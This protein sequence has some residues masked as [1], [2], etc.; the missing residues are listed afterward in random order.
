M[1]DTERCIEIPWAISCYEGEQKVLDIGYA[2]AEDRYL[3][4]IKALRIP[5]LYGLDLA[6][7]EVHGIRSVV[8]DVRR[9]PFR[10][11]VFDLILCISTIE[12]VG[13]D[14]TIYF[15]GRLSQD[16]EG[17]IPAIKEMARI[18]RREGRIVVT[19]PYGRLH[20]YGWFQQYDRQRLDKLISAAGCRVLRDDLYAYKNGWRHAS[21]EDL[22]D[23][24][25]KDNGA[26][27]A[28]GL[29]CLLLER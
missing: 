7:R 10:D 2:Y 13:W 8:G 25:Y 6:S 22:M 15:Q 5:E 29:A 9:A 14:N 28:A 27:A 18:T 11:G 19:V 16:P 26:P 1:G 23:V 20:N 4:A 21:E 17:D 3:E 24:L 12:H